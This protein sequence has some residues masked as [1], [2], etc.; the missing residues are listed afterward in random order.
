MAGRSS[1]KHVS[2]FFVNHLGGSPS[3]ARPRQGAPPRLPSATPKTCGSSVMDAIPYLNG[4][5][6]FIQR[7]R[8]EKEPIRNGRDMAS[9]TEPE[10]IPQHK[11]RLRRPPPGPANRLFHRHPHPF[12]AEMTRT[13]ARDRFSPSSS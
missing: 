2:G 7:V 12:S 3:E 13:W 10:M 1:S 9:F 11:Y 8:K 5:R 6:V 4:K